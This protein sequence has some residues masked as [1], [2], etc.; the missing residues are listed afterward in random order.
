MKH[1]MITDLRQL[2]ASLGSPDAPLALKGY[3]KTNERRTGR[4]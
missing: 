4:A 3:P 2:Q 1:E